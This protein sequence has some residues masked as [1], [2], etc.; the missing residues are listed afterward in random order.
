MLS[1][2]ELDRRYETIAWGLLLWWWG[3][4][5]WP[6]SSLPDGTGLAGTGVILLGITAVRLFYGLS[7][8]RFTRWAGVISLVTGAALIANDVLRLPFKL[9]VF[10]LLLIVLGAGLLLKI[11]FQSV[12]SAEA[13]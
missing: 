8:S 12:R 11:L 1:R 6:L 13:S 9:P 4:R 2:Q 7:V 3:L 5:E 10:E